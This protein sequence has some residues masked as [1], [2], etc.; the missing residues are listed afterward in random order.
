MI[1]VGIIGGAGYTAGELIRLLLIHPD[2]E[3]SFVNSTSNAGNKITDVH[4]DLYGETD[5]V[6]TDEL[7]FSDIDVLFFCTAHGDS[8][9]FMDSHEVPSSLKIIDLSTD[10]RLESPEHDFVY[11]LPELNRRKIC[12]AKHIANPGCFATCIQLGV[13]PLAK[14]LM[15]NSELH[16]NAITGSTGAGVKPSGTSH[17]SWRN[18]N[19]SI[20]KPFEHQHLAEI[21][22]SLS[23]LQNS[24]RSAINFIPVRG[25]FSRGIFA[26][27]Y[28]D[29]KIDLSEIKRIYEEYYSDHSFTFVIDKNPDLKQVINTNKCLIH[30][31]KHNDKLLI[32]SMIDNLLKGASGQ[33]VHNMN[34]IFGLEESVGLH[35]KPS[36]F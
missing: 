14:H 21:K 5:L 8:K 1:N 9:K 6:F 17:F 13:L 31:E 11:G 27:T 12:A 35:L 29:C 4:S 19:I 36:A 25:N 20:Y 16:V 24:F 23:S 33:A 18:D 2:V 7:P 22:Q 32:V 34:L 15:L 28:I 10:F 3:I 26:T 30:L